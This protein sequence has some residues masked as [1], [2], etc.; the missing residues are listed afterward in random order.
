MNNLEK[1]NFLKALAVL[2]VLFFAL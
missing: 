2:Q 1:K